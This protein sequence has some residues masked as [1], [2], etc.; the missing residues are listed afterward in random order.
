MSP[1]TLKDKMKEKGG[2]AVIAALITVS[3]AIGIAALSGAFWTN[4]QVSASNVRQTDLERRVSAV[5]FAGADLN[6]KVTALLFSNPVALQ[7]Y[8]QLK[9]KK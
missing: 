4:S 3:A 7:R 8:N 1:H 5:E 2:Q 9:A 6:D